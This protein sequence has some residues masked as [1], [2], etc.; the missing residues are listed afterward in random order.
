MERERAT[1]LGAQKCLIM[2]FLLTSFIQLACAP[3]FDAEFADQK[4]LASSSP[5]TPPP[6]APP[7]DGEP[8]PTLQ[9]GNCRVPVPLPADIINRIEAACTFTNIE[10]EQA[11]LMPVRLE[12]AHTNVAQDH[13]V[14]MVQNNYFDHRDPDG[15]GFRDRLLAQGVQFDF[16]G[17]NIAFG[18]LLGLEVVNMWMGSGLH[19]QNILNPRYTR[20]G[21]GYYETYWVQVMTD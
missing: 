4:A 17:E 20:M 5:G 21:I 11:G 18:A 2:G 7:S 6:G 16:G 13:A 19:R 9:N 1:T 15:N 3:G 10:R 8:G 12:M 14:D